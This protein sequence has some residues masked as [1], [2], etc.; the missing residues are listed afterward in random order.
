MSIINNYELSVWS[1][2]GQE[3]TKLATIGAQDMLT[4]ARAQAPK[5]IRNINGT[6]T[7]TFS[8]YYEY[9]DEIDGNYYLN[10]FC[11]LLK[12]ESRIKLKWKDKWYEFIVKTVEEDSKTK[13]YHYTATDAFIEELSRKGF[14]IEL[15]TDLENNQGTIIELENKILE[16]SDW[17][18][19]EENSVITPQTKEEVLV[20]LKTTKDIYVTEK[21]IIKFDEET[22]IEKGQFKIPSGS[23]IYTFYSTVYKKDNFFQFYYSPTGIYSF[24]DDAFISN[25]DLYS[26]DNYQY[27]NNLPKDTSEYKI[28]TFKGD[29]L[30]R[31]QITEYDSILDKYVKIYSE[32]SKKIKGYSETEYFTSDFIRNLVTNNTDF[33]TDIGWYGISDKAEVDLF[34]Y[35]DSALTIVNNSVTSNQV[36]S[37]IR[38]KPTVIN[39]Y[40]FYNS[41]FEDN[42]DFLE[43]LYSGQKFVVRLK[44]KYRP[45]KD[46]KAPRD[47]I[48]NSS[49]KRVND[50]LKVN[51]CTYTL[52]DNGEPV[53]SETLCSTT[54][55]GNY[56]NSFKLVD[57][58]WTAICSLPKSFSKTQMFEKKFGLFFSYELSNFSKINA[59]N[60]KGHEFFIEDFQFFEYKEKEENSTDFYIPG[61]TITGEA[62]T[63]YYYFDANQTY[64]NSEDVVYL[65]KGYEE[66]KYPKKYYDNYRQVRTI[67]GKESNIYNLTQTLCETFECWAD[68]IVDHDELGYIRKDNK[69]KLIKKICF[70]PYIGKDNYM[71]FHYKINL[72]SIKRNIESKQITTKTI[73]KPNSN[74]FAPS[75]FCTIAYADENPSGE[76][77][78]YDFRYYESQGLVD[79]K[80][81]SDELYGSQGLYK[82][83]SEL[84]KQIRQK[85][86]A[87][88]EASTQIIYWDKEKQV[89]DATVNELMTSIATEKKDF[90]SY[91]GIT[92]EAFTKLSKAKKE[93]KLKD[94]GVSESYVVIYTQIQE[95]N[96]T[97][98]LLNTANTNYN[99]SKTNYN[100]I[101]QQIKNLTNQKE[102]LILN[103][104]TKYS[105]F[106]QEGTWI[107]E[108][109]NEHN[110]YYIDA[111]AVAATSAMPQV[112]YTINVLDISGI[113][114]FKNYSV[115]IGDKTYITDPEFFGY[116]MIDG[117][118]TP[119]RQEVIISEITEDLE[120]VENNKI[121]VQNYKTQFD[122]LFQ[123]ITAATQQLQLNNGTL[124]RAAG[125][126]TNL[127]LSSTV[128]QAALN[129]TNFLLENNTN[130]WNSQGF[131]STNALDRRQFLKIHNGALLITKDNGETWE[132]AINGK[133]INANY[134]YA[135]QLDAGKI[136]IV[137]ELKTNEDQKLEYAVTMD[138]DGLSMYSYGDNRKLRLRLGKVLEQDL[139]II[140]EL[141]GLQLYN[142]EGKQTFR[143]DSNGDISITGTIYATDGEFSGEIRASS[144]EIGGWEIIDNQLNHYTD[145]KIDAIINTDLLPKY[146]EVNK[147]KDN[148][149]RLLFG[150]DGDNANFGIDSSGYL[151]AHGVDIVDGNISFGDIFK[152]TTNGG[153][154]GAVSYG[155]NITLKPENEDE[156]VVIESD[157]RVIGIREKRKNSNGDIILDDNGKPTWTWKTILGDL[158]HA[159]IGGKTLNELGVEGKYGLFTENGL[160]SGTIFASGGQIGNFV[161]QDNHLYNKRSN[162]TDSFFPSKGE[163]QAEGIFLGKDGTFFIGNRNTYMK[164][165]PEGTADEEEIIDEEDEELKDSEEPLDPPI[166]SFKLKIQADEFYFSS[167]DK[168]KN[169][170][171]E[172]AA[173]ATNFLKYDTTNGLI[174]GH[175]NN[176]NLD[177]ING[178][179][180]I[181]SNGFYI[182]DSSNNIL[183]SFTAEQINLGQNAETSKIS[184]CGNTAEINYGQVNGVGQCLNFYVKKAGGKMF[185]SSPEIIMT[186][187]TAGQYTGGD[188]FVIGDYYIN[189]WCSKNDTYTI[190]SNGATTTSSHRPMVS[191]GLTH[192]TASLLYDS[193]SGGHGGYELTTNGPDVTF[194][195]IGTR[196][197]LNTTQVILP[198][199]GTIWSYRTDDTTT[200]YNLLDFNGSNNMGVGYG[201]YQYSKGTTVI[202]GNSITLTTRNDISLGGLM[203]S[204]IKK[205]VGDGNSDTG[206]VAPTLTSNFE[207]N[208]DN[209]IKYRRVG[210][211]VN[212]CGRFSAKGKDLAQ[213]ED[214]VYVIFTLPEGCRPHQSFST[215]CQG[216]RT[217]SYIWTCEI[218]ENGTVQARNYRAGTT[219]SDFKDNS[220]LNINVSFIVS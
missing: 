161:I 69:G 181:N 76:S 24:D 179:A 125:A 165:G 147:V 139:S 47:V 22:R 187:G 1:V 190:T 176:G 212:I 154:E 171:D 157:D 113:E 137:S 85:I 104:E 51:L 168:V 203:V 8:L 97:K 99:N 130:R 163:T 135:G 5:L 217:G 96:K 148:R 167:G 131:I 34:S 169:K 193:N 140:N 182:K 210:K 82:K 46:T 74:E 19:D 106:I 31:S 209:P 194:S 183:S 60:I 220:L 37:Y 206:W 123:R 29:K 88:T 39:Q 53:V 86:D 110:L 38:I 126:F 101:N 119:K 40:F 70:K 142:A 172:A 28:T 219:T 17:V 115:D 185:L 215:I 55:S 155:L 174:I 198:N 21:A 186:G 11:G 50:G 109:Y 120:N 132:A 118:Y 91:A 143:T 57:N 25:C 128:T 2:N 108:E 10:P 92:Y 67:E 205:V 146:Y 197:H 98:A 145:D 71:G 26:I 81:L 134:I 151:Y 36:D 133:G 207:S 43:N 48:I 173:T 94:E 129:G 178:Y 136:N 61:D 16:R 64:K 149:W 65:Y 116:V 100:N 153:Q 18:V 90:K 41:G 15:S 160:F 12:N 156:A 66:K 196:I 105:S 184:L 177:G 170:I 27:I 213:G 33:V 122:D 72:D 195:I 214:N 58:Y 3:E 102:T 35:P 189:S 188:A 199:K 83:L 121:T 211:V 192:K 9:L 14:N 54:I 166:D 150:I 159:T 141:Y 49:T 114:E 95:Q 162:E 138:K 144:G 180:Q 62:K 152:I 42:K 7:L 204:N 117:F 124:Q 200:K 52:N 4:P 79:S 218:N 201:L 32:G 175:L 45:P 93:E 216:H 77:F 44:Y 111:L 20:T 56:E 103:F 107:S 63:K 127:G 112:T 78:I 6:K 202:Y 30:V 59:N 80:V 89:L 75:R 73:V 191:F 208:S 68:F 13:S 23:L 164:F 87:R 84:N 158:T